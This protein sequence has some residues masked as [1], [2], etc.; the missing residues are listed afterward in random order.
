LTIII[1]F[2]AQEKAF[3]LCKY[4]QV[5]ISDTNKRKSPDN[6]IMGLEI[7]KMSSH[8]YSINFIDRMKEAE[9]W[10]KQN[11]NKLPDMQT[12]MKNAG[13]MGKP[14][15]IYKRLTANNVVVVDRIGRDIYST[16]E[17]TPVFDWEIAT[18]TMRILDQVCLKATCQF[19]GRSYEA[20]FAQ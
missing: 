14:E 1:P 12:M 11:G 10:K 4:K 16:V 19:I 15:N 9:E 13:K 20:W 7:G 5:S 3:L 6:D 2:F 8:F 18:D 17:E